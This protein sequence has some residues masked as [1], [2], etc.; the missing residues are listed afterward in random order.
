MFCAA[1]HK[2]AAN[3]I[4]SFSRRL[5][6]SETQKL[7]RNMQKTSE[8]DDVDQLMTEPS[9]TPTFSDLPPGSC[10]VP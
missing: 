9:E 7:E 8:A 4:D 5:W 6:V 10:V 3:A 2:K 1:V